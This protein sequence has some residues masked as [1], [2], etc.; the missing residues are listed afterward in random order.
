MYVL[1]INCF[2]SRPN[3]DFVPGLPEYFFHDSSAVLLRDGR[4]VAAVEQ[5]RLSRIKHTN[6]FPG[7]AIRA[8]LD[9][10][11][12][13]IGDVDKIAFFFAEEWVDKVLFQLYT[14]HP[15]VEVK[16][17]RRLIA[18]RVREL[19]DHDL[20][21]EV[22]EFV[23]HHE[24]HAYSTYPQSG[25][26]DALVMV[27]DGQGE[28]VSTSFYSATGDQVE[29]LGSKGID[30]S[31]GHLYTAGTEIIGYRL[32]DEYKV[33]GL[34]PYGDPDAYASMFDDLYQLRPDGHFDMDHTR[35]KLLALRAGIVPRRKG[36]EMTQRHMDF[37]AALQR[38]TE[39]LA[40]HMIEHWRWK[41]GHR[42]LAIAGGV[43][44]NCTLNGKL[45]S[46]WSFADVFVHPASHDAGAALGAALKVHREHAGSLPR[47]RVRDVFWG[48]P[49]PAESEAER[50]LAAWDGFLTV[51]RSDRVEEEAAGLLA[52]GRVI[53][54]MQGRSE[55][56][57]RALGN[58]S[59][60]ADPRPME[61]HRR[62]NL[63]VK[64]RESYR[65][66]A[67]SVQAERLRDYF[68]FP[69]DV[70]APDFM[71]F[72][73]P[74]RE[75]KRDELAAITHVD[76]SARVHAVDRAVNERYWLLLEAFEKRTGVPVVLNTSFNNHA[77][78]IVDSVQDG[79]RC[80]LTTRLDHLVIGDLVVSKTEPRPEQLLRL[81]LALPGYAVL[82]KTVT[83]DGAET[84]R[85]THNHATAKSAPISETTFE[86]LRKANGTS[87]LAELGLDITTSAGLD[88][89][90]ELERLWADRLLDLAPAH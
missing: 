39:R 20:P 82:E 35:L 13:S 83:A 53:G 12:I 89:L 48:P 17:T 10:A 47:E 11:G 32:F 50:L 67:P 76:G 23:P 90:R 34:A 4:V 54:W 69:S 37:A 28:G 51:R 63:M 64:N 16:W 87:T 78:P 15:G 58:R 43:G 26:D 72:T 24:S 68:E 9:R 88:T 66:F 84:G 19:F 59:I 81:V 7:D 1:G 80:F 56:G 33:M 73:V 86:I 22:M 62:V 41:T 57:P 27:M 60:L 55:F 3:E 71:V 61:N 25:Y 75:E 45:L 79:I 18:E 5:E 8:C 77:E 30:R 29:L 38:A 31:I 46:G 21:D 85:L 14:Q 65:P 40:T 6:R 52:D 44:Q 74:V 49:L 42:R 70:P 2:F 36:E